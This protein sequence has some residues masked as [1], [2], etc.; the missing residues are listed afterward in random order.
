MANFPII[1]NL[2]IQPRDPEYLDRKVG[3]R[4]Q[5]YFDNT[6]NTLRLYTGKSE[7][8]GGIPLA[9]ADL[10]NISNADFLAKAT[11]AGVSSGGGGGSAEFSFSADDSTIQTVAAGNSVKFLGGTGISTNSTADELTITND[12]N[13]F[14]TISVAGQSDVVADSLTDTLTLVAGAN[15][16]II[17][18][19]TTDTITI[20]ASTGSGGI[21]EIVEDTT[22]VLGGQLDAG[23]F[24][25]TQLGTPTADADAT[26]KAYVDN[27]I[28]PANNYLPAITKLV[29]DNNGVTAYTFDQYTGNNP[30]I[31]A[32]N[33]TTIAFDLT[34]IEGHPFEIQT[35][36]GAAYNTGLYHVAPDGTVSTGSNAQ[37]KTSGVLYWK[38]PTDISGG[39]RY[40]CQTHAA[41]VGSLTIKDIAVI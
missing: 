2:R 13:V 3:S 25:I 27:L 34:A 37:G 32:I 17:T 24:K 23:G 20:S 7:A 35:P 26:T 4:G 18:D 16:T 8:V 6:A 22:P 10:N 9:R 38:I 30:T 33:G 36:A 41:M 29:V 31:Y 40:Q 19:D 21:G 14:S 5:I 28:D 11:A 12:A 1:N 39:Y 15:V